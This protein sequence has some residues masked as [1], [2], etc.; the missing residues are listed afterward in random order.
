MNA[1]QEH[2]QKSFFFFSPER[3]FWPPH[4]YS[5]HHSILEKTNQKNFK[6]KKAVAERMSQI[7][8]ASQPLSQSVSQSARDTDISP[9]PGCG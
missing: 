1:Y 6:K 2:V 9:T 8:P 3:I 4:M 7:Q 5:K